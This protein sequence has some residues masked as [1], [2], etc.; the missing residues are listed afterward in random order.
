MLNL[1]TYDISDRT[2]LEKSFDNLREKNK[3]EIIM[4]SSE[5]DKVFRQTVDNVKNP[6]NSNFRFQNL[7]KLA[8]ATG[9]FYIGQCLIDFGYP[10]GHRG[11]QT[12]EQ[13]YYFQAIGIANL[14]IDL[15]ITHLRPETKIDK[16]INRYFNYDI[17]FDKMEKFNEKYYLT[18]NKRKEV[19]KYFD[20]NFLDIISRHNDILI[21]TNR[22]QMFVS[23]DTDLEVNQLKIIQDIFL[24][25]NYLEDLYGVQQ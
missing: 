18:S 14:K 4:A 20:S 7:F 5:K 24:N 13:K 12:F 22:N 17:E 23:F 11:A 3:V 2:L 9:Q 6:N 21:S 25:F 1:V 8:S 10:V 16:L 15:G 19:L